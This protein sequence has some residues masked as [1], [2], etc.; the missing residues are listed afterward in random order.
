M[1]M[2][3]YEVFVLET[4]KITTS[5]TSTTTAARNLRIDVRS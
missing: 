5:T 1:M 4:A 2:V 3:N